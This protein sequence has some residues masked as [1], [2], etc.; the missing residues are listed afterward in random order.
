L[1]I[2]LTP[3]TAT[4]AGAHGSSG[5]GTLTL[6]PG[7][8]PNTEDG[9]MASHQ[10]PPPPAS[11]ASPAK[12]KKKGRPPGATKSKMKL[13]APPKPQ[14]QT[15]K[16]MAAPVGSGLIGVNPHMLI[17]QAGQDVRSRVMSFSCNGWAVC[18]VSANGTISNV[19]LRQGY[20]SG[21]TVTY[22]DRFEILSLAGSYLLSECGGLSSR[23][24]SLTVSL[25][26]RDGRVLAGSVAG[27]LIAASPVQVPLLYRMLFFY[28]TSEISY[29]L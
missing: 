25:V 16:Q 14:P 8:G 9:A 11:Q 6:P 23:T 22:E 2:I 3:S 20:S 19:T 1:A 13:K 27:P 7:F 28:I 10:A 5:P 18:V 26:G 15:Q 12:N 29:L 17:V 24:G 4:A 21:G